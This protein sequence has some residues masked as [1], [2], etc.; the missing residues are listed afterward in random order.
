MLIDDVGRTVAFYRD[1]L[2][3]EVVMTAP[4]DAPAGE[5]AWALLKRGHVE[6]LFQ[7]R[8]SVA[9]LL[10]PPHPR[11]STLTIY[12]DLADVE[13]FY[14]RLAPHVALEQDLHDAGDMRAFSLRD[15]NGF[16]LTFAGPRPAA[17]RAA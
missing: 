11:R 7:T 6:L 12:V 10:P 15:C 16:V 5:P 9:G 2:G 17:R 8:D 14:R 1:V 13:A 3:F 4:A